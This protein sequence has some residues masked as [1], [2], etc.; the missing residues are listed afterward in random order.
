MGSIY[1]S[2]LARGAF[3][4]V[5][6]DTWREHVDAIG[7][8]G[9][10]VQG[11]EGT[12]TIRIAATSDPAEAGKADLVLLAVKSFQSASAV[13]ALRQVLEPDSVILVMQN[14]LNNGER[15]EHLLDRAVRLAV[16]VPGHGGRLLGP[17]LVTHRVSGPTEIGW[18]H[19]PATGDLH[20]LAAAMTAAGFET[21]AV[22][23]VERLLWG[24]V[25]VVAGVNAI[26]ALCRV[27]NIDIARQRDAARLSELVIEEVV[28]VGVAKGVDLDRD[29]LINHCRAVYFGNGEHHLSSMTIDVLSERPTEIEAINGAIVEEGRRLGVPTPYNETL[30]LLVRTVGATAPRRAQL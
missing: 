12:E 19:A 26:A 13:D 23:D 21:A 14:G 30:T 17:G 22:D 15:L 18:L 10:R 24:H 11:S 4:V 3:E 6:V 9:L 2:L 28:E 27:P 1:A 29:Q 8:H 7:R 25:V 20:R 16:G 5:L